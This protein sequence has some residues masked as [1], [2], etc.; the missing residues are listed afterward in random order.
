MFMPAYLHRS[1]DGRE[2][3]HRQVFAH[4]FLQPKE[5]EEETEQK[6]FDLIRKNTFALSREVTLA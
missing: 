6:S 4:G 2:I 3:R 5:A 1:S